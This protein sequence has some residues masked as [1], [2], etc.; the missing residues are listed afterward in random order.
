MKSGNTVTVEMIDALMNEAKVTAEKMGAKTT[1]VHLTLPNGFEFVESYSCVDAAN[2]DMEIWLR[3]CLNR[4]RDQLLKME[5]YRLQCEVAT[6]G[7]NASVVAES[8]QDRVRAE[9]AE[10]EEKIT[11]L[12]A[13]ISCSDVFEGLPGAE[14]DRLTAQLGF[15]T[16]YGLVLS[17]RIKAF[18]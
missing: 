4:I 9:K 18:D 3:I 13:F 16:S 6:C 1:V 5:G 11:A 2:F 12:N 15:M 17:D 7:G 8:F 14:K 10:L